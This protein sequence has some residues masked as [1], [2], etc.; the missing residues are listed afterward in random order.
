MENI[1]LTLIEYTI[2]NSDYYILKMQDFTNYNIHYIEEDDIKT[3]SF[4]YVIKY[5]N[6]KY[7][8]LKFVS[9]ENVISNLKVTLKEDRYYYTLYNKNSLDIFDLKPNQ[10]YHISLE[11]KK[12]NIFFINYTI[13]VQD[14]NENDLPLESMMIYK[15]ISEF[16]S[17]HLSSFIYYIKALSESYLYL[18]S[19]FDTKYLSLN[20][21]PQFQIEKFTFAYNITKDIKTEFNLENNTLCSISELYPYFIYKFNINSKIL[22]KLEYEIIIQNNNISSLPFENIS[23]IEK[24]FK[25]F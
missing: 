2:I 10:T 3:I 20:I 6:T 24:S 4:N 23:V 17:D 13:N 22:E 1:N 12:N 16:S 18:V 25:C 14:F 5:K 11:A 9:L 21:T 7:F 19:E 8:C 15:N